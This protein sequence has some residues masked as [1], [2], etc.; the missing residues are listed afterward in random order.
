M[1]DLDEGRL[2]TAH[3]LG[4]HATV[5]SSPDAE[6]KLMDLTGGQ[7]F[8]SVIEAVGIPATFELC[9][10]VVAVGGRIANVGVHGTK[11][12]LHLERLW[13]RNISKSKRR[14]GEVARSD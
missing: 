5:V 7:G 8:D 6:Q 3:S 4:A 13:E 14:E 9:Q 1:V 2:A 12:D 11:V 10:K